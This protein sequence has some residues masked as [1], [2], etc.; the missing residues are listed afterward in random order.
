MHL[1]MVYEL[2]VIPVFL[3][4]SECLTLRKADIRK[5]LALEM[6]S[7]IKS[8]G[9]SRLQRMKILEV[10]SSKQQQCD[11]IQRGR[12]RWFGHVRRMDANRLLTK[13]MSCNVKGKRNR[14][15][16]PNIVRSSF[17]LSVRD[18]R[19]AVEVTRDRGK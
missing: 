1:R 17:I 19:A 11:K 2:L 13:V 8:L 4:G 7:L 12:L 10:N 16:Q 15:R 14:G 3:C 6:S 18:I 5:I 9:V